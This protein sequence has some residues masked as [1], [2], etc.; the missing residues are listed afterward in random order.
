LLQ[1]LSPAI[2]AQ[3][4]NINEAWLCFN[5]TLFARKSDCGPDLACGPEFAYLFSRGLI[6]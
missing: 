3:N 4:E 6:K 2:V 5:K 1:P